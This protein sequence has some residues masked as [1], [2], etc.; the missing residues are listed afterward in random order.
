MR[1][2]IARTLNRDA[3]NE[4]IIEYLEHGGIEVVG[5][6]KRNQWAADAFAMCLEED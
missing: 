4:S 2:E 1:I 5:I 3:S 6:T